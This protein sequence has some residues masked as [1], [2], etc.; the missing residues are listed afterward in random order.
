MNFKNF[1]HKIFS[2]Y[3]SEM[4]TKFPAALYAIGGISKKHFMRSSVEGKFFKSKLFFSRI[5]NDENCGR[6][7]V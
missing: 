3:N 5:R 1:I 4:Y 7:K 6:S 2:C